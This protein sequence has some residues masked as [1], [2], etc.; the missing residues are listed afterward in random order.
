MDVLVE[1]LNRGD[2]LLLL[3]GKEVVIDKISKTGDK[4]WVAW[5]S[6]EKFHRP[7]RLAGQWTY[8]GTLKPTRIGDFVS[9]AA[10]IKHS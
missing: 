8:V 2:R 1:T 10:V 9:V 5:R 4:L 7:H 6:R 3:N